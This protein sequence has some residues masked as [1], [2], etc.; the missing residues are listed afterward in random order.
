[1]PAYSH[2]SKSSAPHAQY[3][4]ETHGELQ[5]GLSQEWV[6]TNGIGSFAGSSIVGAN[7]RRYHGLLCAATQ[8]PLGRVMTLSRIGEILKLDGDDQ[9]HELSVNCFGGGTIH[10]RGDRFLRRFKLGD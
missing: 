2:S 4:I 8:P 7:T 10:P 3:V 6:L 5:P 1:M 9:L